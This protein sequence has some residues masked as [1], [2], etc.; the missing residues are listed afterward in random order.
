L[1]IRH[2]QAI[3]AV[4]TKESALIGQVVSK[5]PKKFIYYRST[6]AIFKKY[7]SALDPKLK[8]GSVNF[9]A[10][11]KFFE[12]MVTNEQ[13]FSSTKTYEEH[14][15]P[16]NDFAMALYDKV[17]GKSKDQNHAVTAI[18]SQSANM[19]KTDNWCF[20]PLCRGRKKFASHTWENCFRNRKSAHYKQQASNRKGAEESHT[21][22]HSRS[23]SSKYHNGGYRK[24]KQTVYT[25]I[26]IPT[27]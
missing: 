25:R 6:Q 7:H 13:E 18:I 17:Y 21:K 10:F 27:V 1:T 9:T 26:L 15:F 8:D 23:Q 20:H 5:E 22:L 4:G 12:F 2:V 3:T 11:A 14:P 16:N 19:A 24:D